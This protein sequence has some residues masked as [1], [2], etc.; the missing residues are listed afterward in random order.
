[1]GTPFY[2]YVSQVHRWFE[3]DSYFNDPGSIYRDAI[4]RTVC[5][6]PACYAWQFLNEQTF[7]DHKYDFLADT[8]F[9]LLSYPS[10]DKATGNMADPYN[11]QPGPNGEDRYPGSMGFDP[12]E[13]DAAE[14]L[15]VELAQPL[16][17]YDKFFNVRGVQ[18]K[19][20]FPKPR[21][22]DRTRGAV[23]WGWADEA[24]PIVDA[25]SVPGDGT[26]P[27]YSARLL[28]LF[29]QQGDHVFTLEDY[30]IQHML[31]MNQKPTRDALAG[32]L[33]N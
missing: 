17:S 9:P 27:A 12:V 21:P 29:L 8:E 25:V 20:H 7:V 15:V 10:L 13:L 18:L 22:A 26:Q 23:W 31:M 11:P 2:G 6:L 5:A 16:D 4:I 28:E 30:K 33:L 14:A 19:V 3:G 24:Q 32:L 1:V